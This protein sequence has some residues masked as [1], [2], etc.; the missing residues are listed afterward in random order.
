MNDHKEARLCLQLP[1]L[2]PFPSIGVNDKSY[3]QSLT[4][5]PRTFGKITYNSYNF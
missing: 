5:N 1:A 4:S 3:V 2:P